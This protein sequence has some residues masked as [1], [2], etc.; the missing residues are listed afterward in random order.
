M[1]Q[2]LSNLVGTVLNSPIGSPFGLALT[3]FALAGFFITILILIG[4]AV[5][6]VSL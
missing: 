5:V 4:L 2:A 1:L 6:G 3:A